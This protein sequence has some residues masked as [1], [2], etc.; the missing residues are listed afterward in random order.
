M[1]APE[2]SLSLPGL[3]P[4][5][6]LPFRPASKVASNGLEKQPRETSPFSDGRQVLCLSDQEVTKTLGFSLN[7]DQDEVPGSIYSLTGHWGVTLPGDL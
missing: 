7:A 1:G 4:L 5:A 6:P 2:V 3:S